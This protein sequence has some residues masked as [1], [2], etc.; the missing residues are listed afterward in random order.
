MEVQ[1]ITSTSKSLH[2]KKK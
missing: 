1:L 2:K